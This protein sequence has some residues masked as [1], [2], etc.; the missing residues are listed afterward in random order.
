MNCKQMYFQKKKLNLM[1]LKMIK[2]GVLC[3]IAIN[4]LKK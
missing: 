2:Q 3:R 1:T 4:K